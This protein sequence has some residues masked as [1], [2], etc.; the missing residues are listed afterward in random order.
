MN[1]FTQSQYLEPAVSWRVS[2]VRYR[3]SGSAY[4]AL[5]D[6]TL[7]IT[8]GAFTAILGPNGAGKSSLLH[9]LTGTRLPESGTIHLQGIPITEWPLARLARVVGVV[10]QSETIAFSL[11][12]RDAVAM[13]RYPHLGAWQRESA[14]DKRIIAAA[15]ELC[16]VAQFANRDINK[17]SG[18]ERQRVRIARALAQQP[19]ILALDEPT[20]AL[21]IEHEMTVFELLKSLNNSGITVVLITHH[22]N[23]AARYADR[24][25]VLHQ[26]RV[27]AEG[28]PRDVLTPTLVEHVWQWPI[29]IDTHPGP[30]RD[31]GT[32]Q[33]I[34]LAQPHA[35]D[36]VSASVAA[37]GSN[38][39]PSH[40]FTSTQ[41]THV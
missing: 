12:V 29:V 8:E 34:P 40:T 6:V 35:F 37:V 41:L 13:G 38:S 39:L 5:E 26:G 23:L 1:R 28:A 22:V 3:P 10:S 27:A 16:D 15:M 4:Y 7:N 17:L 14:E 2:N 11:S 30:G 9:L 21:D 36:H 24:L 33:I 20:A 31:T 19:S 25:I 18:G 32:T